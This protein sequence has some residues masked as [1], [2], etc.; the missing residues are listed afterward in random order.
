MWR[1]NVCV[2]ASAESSFPNTSFREHNKTPLCNTVVL[3]YKQILR[4][5][6][7]VEQREGWV[8]VGEVRLASVEL[9][10]GGGFL[11]CFVP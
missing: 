11:D 5:R 7:S 4:V 9:D 3:Q 6:L 2:S 10:P 8:W 1:L